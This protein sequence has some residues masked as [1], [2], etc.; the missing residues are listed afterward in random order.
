MY[1]LSCES[2]VDLPK[3]YIQKRNIHAISYTYIINGK[4]YFDNME[5]D[6]SEFYKHLENGAMPTTSLICVERYKDYFRNLLEKGDLLHIAF[7]SGLSR[8]VENAYRAAEELK[9]DYPD[10]K[11][12]V[13]DSLCGCLGYGLLVD[14]LADMRDS[15]NSIDEVYNWAM[16]NRANVHHQFFTTT[17]KYFRKSGRVSTPAALIGDLLKICPIMRVDKNG[18]IIVYSKAI[19]VKKAI[20]KTAQEVETHIYGG[21]DYGDR[22]W[23]AHSSCRENA[24]AMQKRLKESYP[25]ADVRL[26]NIGPIIG[27]H[28]GPGTVAVYFWG[29]ERA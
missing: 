2:T 4:E 29:D 24:E 15:L 26:W 3:E 25:Y 22:I 17:L 10:R 21:K 13:V 19:S 28:C 27:S 20:S 12:Y 7:D 1:I 14:T 5:E 16:I 11:I 18:R 8:S 6:K 9:Q 23:I